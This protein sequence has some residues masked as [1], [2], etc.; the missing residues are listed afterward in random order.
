MRRSYRSST[1]VDSTRSNAAE[2]LI[3]SAAS[4]AIIGLTT[5]VFCRGKCCFGAPPAVLLV[6]LCTAH[7]ACTR[8]WGWRWLS[9]LSSVL[10]T[11]LVQVLAVG[12]ALRV[13]LQAELFP[14]AEYLGFANCHDRTARCTTYIK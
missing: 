3:L 4:E 7:F 2:T 5:H 14:P 8:G 11:L 9:D 6:E 1:E 10:R 12:V 13:L